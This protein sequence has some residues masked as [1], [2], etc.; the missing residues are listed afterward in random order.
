LPQQSKARFYPT[1]L[2]Q[3]P[4]MRACSCLQYPGKSSIGF[5]DDELW[6]S[7]GESSLR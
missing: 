6:K 1:W 4:S 5:V 7:H 3:R 2:A